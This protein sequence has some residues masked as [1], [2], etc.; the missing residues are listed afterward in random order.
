MQ[1][2]R[3]LACVEGPDAVTPDDGM[4]PEPHFVDEVLAREVV[5]EL[6]DSIENQ[7]AGLAGLQVCDLAGDVGAEQL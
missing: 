7:I 5:R 2:N 4:H 6:A 1:S 3:K